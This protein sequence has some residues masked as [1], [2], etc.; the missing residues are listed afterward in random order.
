MKNNNFADMSPKLCII[1]KIYLPTTLT[2]CSGERSFSALKR[3]KNYL[4]TTI[5][6]TD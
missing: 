5:S 4:R 6:T 1:F 3:V 2:N